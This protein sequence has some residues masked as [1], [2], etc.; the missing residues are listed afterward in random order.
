MDVGYAFNLETHFRLKLWQFNGS[1]Y[2]ERE[3]QL[4]VVTF[5]VS[6]ANANRIVPSQ[7]RLLSLTVALDVDVR[8]GDT[9]GISPIPAQP[10]CVPEVSDGQITCRAFTI[11]VGA[12]I[13]IAE[14]A[15]F[16]QPVLRQSGPCWDFTRGAVPCSF[17]Y[18][19]GRPHFEIGF[20]ATSP[21]IHV[22]N[23]ESDSSEDP[24]EPVV[25]CVCSVVAKLLPHLWTCCL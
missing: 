25:V 18:L 19:I 15:V 12:P 7:H 6:D 4:V 11:I 9:L 21:P 23:P 2:E 24:D 13:V 17:L 3:S 1:G 16:G 22:S 10:S 20:Q 5:R 14:D 8:A